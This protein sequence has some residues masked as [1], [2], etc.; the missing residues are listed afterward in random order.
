MVLFPRRF[1]D[2][3]N[4]CVSCR[5]AAGGRG[6]RNSPVELLARDLV[7]DHTTCLL[8]F[9]GYERRYEY[10][11]PPYPAAICFLFGAHWR[12]C[13]GP[14][15]AEPAMGLRCCGASA[16]SCGFVPLDLPRLSRLL[17]RTLGRTVEHLQIPDRFEC[18]LGTT[19]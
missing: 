13:M 11:G 9:S 15:S 2:Q 19:A 5:H 16:F 12:C 3:V 4:A 14:Y 7:S 10:R 6:H 17:K 18:R 8:S 1:C